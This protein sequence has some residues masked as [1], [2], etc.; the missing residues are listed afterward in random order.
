MSLK[1]EFKSPDLWMILFYYLVSTL[2]YSETTVSTKLYL[3]A[4]CFNLR[5]IAL[6]H[7]F[8][9]RITYI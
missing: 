8:F 2:K 3:N 5:E 7:H 4:G 9:G 1:F 6:I